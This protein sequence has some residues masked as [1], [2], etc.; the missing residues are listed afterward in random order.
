MWWT[1]KLSSIDLLGLNTRKPGRAALRL[2][3]PAERVADLRKDYQNMQPM[4]FGTIPG[5]ED[6]LEELADLE[7]AINNSNFK[8]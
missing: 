8:V 4:L 5:F 7:K 6:I 1:L 3:P 2:S